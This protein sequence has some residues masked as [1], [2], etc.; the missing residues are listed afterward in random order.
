[1][2]AF[3]APSREVCTL[4]RVMTSTPLQAFV[5]LNDPVYVECSQSLARRIARE[6]G[7]SPEDRAAFALKL[8]L[9]HPPEPEQIARVVSLY[10]AQ[11][12]HYRSDSADAK[13]MATEPAGPV[14]T[15]MKEDDLAAWT[16][17]ANVLLNLDGVLTNH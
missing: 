1:M 3:D 9:G 6:G 2:S 16:V 14:P 5:T 4:R 12:E 15:G 13:K 7:E 17:C 8:C 11:L 10:N